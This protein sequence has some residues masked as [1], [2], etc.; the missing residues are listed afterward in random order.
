MHIELMKPWL[1]SQPA[2]NK[3]GGGIHTYNSNTQEVRQE[4]KD[5]EVTVGCCKF[6]DSLGCKRCHSTKVSFLCFVI[7]YRCV[8]GS[9]CM[10]YRCVWKQKGLLQLQSQ[11]L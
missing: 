8:L 7:M 1:Q 2:L 5:F 4:D 10:E 3:L 6:K 9:T 11:C